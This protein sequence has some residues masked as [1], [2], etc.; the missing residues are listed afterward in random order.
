MPP[1]APDARSARRQLLSVGE[2]AAQP[3]A[4]DLPCACSRQVGDPEDAARPLVIGDTPEQPGSYAFGRQRPV[5]HHNGADDLSPAPV[6]HPHHSAL[7]DVGMVVKY[8]LDV[9]RIDVDS[10]ADDEIV[11]AVDQVNVSVLVD[12]ADVTNRR[13]VIAPVQVTTGI[14]VALERQRGAYSQHSSL[15]R[16]QLARAVEC[17]YLDSWEWASA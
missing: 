4:G 11:G 10:A 8:G 15:A 7:P 3:A 1:C 17:R 14:Q 12:V 6:R 2:D 9:G 5:S 13:P 16:A